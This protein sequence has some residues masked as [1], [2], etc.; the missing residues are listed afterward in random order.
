MTN[1]LIELS[2]DAAG[3]EGVEGVCKRPDLAGALKRQAICGSSS[4]SLPARRIYRIQ[5]RDPR[6]DHRARSAF[7]DPL[8]H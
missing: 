1:C 6:S 7:P 3:E 5:R 4:S 2:P 8:Q